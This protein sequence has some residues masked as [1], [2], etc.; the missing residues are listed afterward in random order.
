MMGRAGVRIGHFRSII[1]G[2]RRKRRRFAGCPVLQ[3]D[4]HW[5]GHEPIGPSAGGFP[6][7]RAQAQ[8]FKVPTH[9]DLGGG[10]F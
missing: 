8:I 4:H 1:V 6:W 2:C 5:Q 10:D 9:H 3:V 7:N